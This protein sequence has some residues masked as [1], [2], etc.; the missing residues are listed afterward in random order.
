M[1]VDGIRIAVTASEHALD[2]DTNIL[3]FAIAVDK[4][5]GTAG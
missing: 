4:G 5:V 2:E 1:A 3:Q